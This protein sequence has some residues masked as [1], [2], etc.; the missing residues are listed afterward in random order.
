MRQSESKLARRI[1]VTAQVSPGV[2]DKLAALAASTQRTEAEVATAAITAYVEANA[3]HIDEIKRSI[4]EVAR[5]VPTVP[6]EDVVAWLDSW[7]T[8]R[9]LPPPKPRKNRG[10]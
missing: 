10:R 8:E 3:W 1:P 2:K 5:G 4:A 6:H 7:G 9:E